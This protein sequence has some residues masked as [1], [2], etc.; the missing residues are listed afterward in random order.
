[1]TNL[2]ATA[3]IEVSASAARVWSALTDPAQIKQY[4]FGSEVETTWKPGDPI[5]WKGEYE[6]TSYEDKGEIIEVDPE[7]RL[8][9]THFSAMSGQPDEPEN[10]HRLTY[11]VH[12]HGGS[13]HLTLSQDGNKSEDEAEQAK[14]NWTAMLT[15]LKDVVER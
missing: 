7:K 1:M 11:E 14:K 8:V 10:Y 5:V 4:M 12:A 13:A 9:V 2:V 15:S 6:G 3:Q